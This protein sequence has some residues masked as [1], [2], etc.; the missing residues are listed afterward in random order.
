M[1]GTWK[2]AKQ[3]E[4]LLGSCSHFELVEEEAGSKGCCRKQCCAEKSYMKE[5]VP[6][7]YTKFTN[8]KITFGAGSQGN[9]DHGGW[10]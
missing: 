1:A 7:E 2:P 6:C 9:G 8:R 4:L 3:S 5:L 10:W